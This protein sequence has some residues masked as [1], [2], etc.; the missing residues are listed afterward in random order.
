MQNNSNTLQQV[1][2][3]VER[4]TQ[5]GQRRALQVRGEW[6]STFNGITD[7]VQEGDQVTLAYS[8]VVKGDRT[9]HNI[10]SLE[11]TDKAAQ[12]ASTASPN[13]AATELRTSDKDKRISRSVALKCA[14]ENRGTGA[15]LAR[16]EAKQ[17]VAV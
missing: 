3:I 1:Q 16:I 14:I 10:K 15:E 12:S 13:G 9:F 8:S 6:F 7:E 11:I 17:A 5:N 2:G 4:L